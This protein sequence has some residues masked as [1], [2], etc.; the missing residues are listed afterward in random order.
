MAGS[1]KTIPCEDSKLPITTVSVLISNR[2]EHQRRSPDCSFFA[3]S[4]IPKSKAG[5][6]KKARA[7]KISR[8][9]TQSNITILSEDA[10]I[11][12]TE[13]PVV[14]IVV[15]VVEAAKTVKS[16]K[17]AKKGAKGTKSAPKPKERASRAVD[18]DTQVPGAFPEPED[19]DFEVK[20]DKPLGQSKEGKK[21]KSDAME[22]T[23]ETSNHAGA[24]SQE[25]DIEDRPKKRRAT[26][27]RGSAA[28]TYNELNPPQQEEPNGNAPKEHAEEFSSPAPAQDRKKKKGGNKRSSSRVRKASTTSTASKASLRA[29]IPPDA[30][31][32]AELE[33]ELDRPLTDE[34]SDTELPVVTKPKG[35]RLTRTKPGSRKATASVALTRRT[36]RASAVPEDTSMQDAYPSLSKPVQPA[37]GPTPQKDEDAASAL[38]TPGQSSSPDHQANCKSLSNPEQQNGYEKARRESEEAITA[39]KDKMVEEIPMSES[40]QSRSKQASRISPAHNIRVADIPRSSEAMDL[41]SDVN[42]SMLGAQTAQDDSGH[43]TDA[44]AMKQARTKHGSKKIRTKKVKGG[45]KAA[46]KNRKIEREEE[47]TATTSVDIQNDSGEPVRAE[48][49]EPTEEQNTS[50]VVAKLGKTDN[51]LPER[52]ASAEEVSAV[53][54]M[55]H[56]S[57]LVETDIARPSSQSETKHSTSVAPSPQS[58]D[59]ENHPPSSSLSKP[60]PQTLTQS[61]FKSQTSRVPLAATTPT[62]SPS[63]NKLSSLQTTFPWTAVDLEHVFE[64]TLSTGKENSPFTLGEAGEKVKG[65]LTSP[66]KRLTVEQWIQSNAQRGEERLRNECERLVG[67]FEDQGVRALR[68]LEGIVCAE[69]P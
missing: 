37:P 56:P 47:S 9:S 27:T 15:P 24:H 43:E 28:Q 36:T 13:V 35:R 58:S 54:L 7:S 48:V 30:E 49:E 53:P 64:S 52:G 40:Q 3:R 22:K 32:D 68:V 29:T 2:D 45:K 6:S 12:D 42:S 23:N 31:I 61:P 46:P 16:G 1:R 11:A 5:R 10:S 44:S 69:R 4:A 62:G 55:N 57:M 21:R 67:R 19:D 34:E 20:V 8:T 60:G 51:T 63:R 26:R 18:E 66:E 25:E 41:N 38:D 50:E 14:G 39:V 65:L 17:G 59:A 33:A